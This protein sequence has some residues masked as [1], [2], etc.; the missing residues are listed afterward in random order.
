MPVAVRSK[1]EFSGLSIAG[2][3]GSEPSDGMYILFQVFVA[4]CVGRQRLLRWRVFPDVC[5]IVCDLQTSTL[6][7][8]WHDLFCKPQRVFSNFYLSHSRSAAYSHKNRYS[9]SNTTV[10]VV[11]LR[12]FIHI[13]YLKSNYMFRSFFLVHHQVDLTS[14]SRPLYNT[15][16]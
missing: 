6:C 5:L 13:T 14:Y 1:A 10:N 16:Y 3:A 2:V 12:S 11:L 8:T 7:R 15:Q 4:C 9:K